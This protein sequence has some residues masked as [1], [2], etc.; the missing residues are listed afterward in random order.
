[1]AL[2]VEYLTQISDYDL[3]TKQEVFY[4]LSRQK[5]PSEVCV[6]KIRVPSEYQ[7]P[8]E[9]PIDSRVAWRISPHKIT[10]KKADN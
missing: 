10:N 7:I 2:K 9:L 6:E 5:M 8:K 1:M 3:S 4:V